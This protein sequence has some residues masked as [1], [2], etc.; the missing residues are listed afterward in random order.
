MHGQAEFVRGT[1][2]WHAWS[3]GKIPPRLPLE[4]GGVIDSGRWPVFKVLW[5]RKERKSAHVLFCHCFGYQ[6][7]DQSI[8]FVGASRL[9]IR[10]LLQECQ[11]LMAWRSSSMILTSP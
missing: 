2:R 4:K 11:S 5:V 3:L 9:Q 7:E 8:L 6:L 1:S 10:K